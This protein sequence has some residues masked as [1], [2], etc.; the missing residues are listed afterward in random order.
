L[1]ADGKLDLERASRDFLNDAT[2]LLDL[3]E[4]GVFEFR[5][6]TEIARMLEATGFLVEKTWSSFGDPPQAVVLAARRAG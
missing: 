2:R 4:M 3:E 5:D 1:N 6:A